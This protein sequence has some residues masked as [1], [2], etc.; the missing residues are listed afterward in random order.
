MTW[1]GASNKNT[2]V[3]VGFG[4]GIKRV[5]GK[6]SS[7]FEFSAVLR[8]DPNLA[9]DEIKK[10]LDNNVVKTRTAELLLLNANFMV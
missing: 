6:P 1:T 4:V 7:L 5:A 9:S 8:L 10:R 3:A 2:G